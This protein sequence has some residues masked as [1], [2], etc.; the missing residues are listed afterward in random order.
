MGTLRR[1][2]NLC[3]LA[4][5][6]TSTL[7]HSISIRSADADPSDTGDELNLIT[8]DD[9]P[10]SAL[11]PLEH[12][13]I[14]YLAD[15][16][17]PKDIVRA[18]FKCDAG[19]QISNGAKNIYCFYGTWSDEM[20]ECVAVPCPEIESP[21][22]GYFQWIGPVQPY[23]THSIAEFF[24]AE[25]YTHGNVTETAL[26]C[27]ADGTW[28]ST[29]PQ[30]QEETQNL[31]DLI[32]E[33]TS[34]SV[35]SSGLTCF[36]GTVNYEMGS[37]DIV[38]YDD[39]RSI[40]CQPGQTQCFKQTITIGSE[41]WEGVFS[42][43]AVTVGCYNPQTDTSRMTRSNT[44]QYLPENMRL[45]AYQVDLCDT[46]S[47]S[48]ITKDSQETI[49][50]P[51]GLT[52]TD[53]D[54]GAILF[55]QESSEECKVTSFCEVV[56][57]SSTPVGTQK[58]R[59][60]RYTGCGGFYSSN[61]DF[62]NT[63]PV[64]PEASDRVSRMT[65]CQRWNC[66]EGV[67]GLCVCP[68]DFDTTEVSVE[69]DYIPSYGDEAEEVQ[70]SSPK[71]ELHCMTGTVNYN[72]MTA[73]FTYDDTRIEKC[74]SGQTMCF[75]E[76]AVVRGRNMLVK[77][78]NGGC[79]N[80]SFQ[81]RYTAERMKSYLSQT[82]QIR[83]YSFQTCKETNCMDFSD[84]SETISCYF[85]LMVTDSNSGESMF[86]HR[87]VTS[88]KIHETCE[89]VSLD[90]TI[91]STGQRLHFQY[92][93]CG[94]PENYKFDWANTMPIIPPSIEVEKR[95][96]ACADLGCYESSLGL[97]SCPDDF[98][99]DR[100]ARVSVQH[101]ET[102]DSNKCNLVTA[103][104]SVEDASSGT[105][106]GFYCLT[107]TVNQEYESGIV[108]Y[109][110]TKLQ[111]CSYE[112][113]ECYQ[114]TIV[115]NIG[116]WPIKSTAGGCLMATAKRF[117]SN[118]NVLQQ[119]F[120]VDSTITS[121]D[122]ETCSQPGCFNFSPLT[123]RNTITCYSGLTVT[124]ES[125]GRVLFHHQ[126]AQRCKIHNF[127]QVQTLQSTDAHT[128]ETK[129]FR[130]S[131][132]GDPAS[133]HYEWGN[134]LAVVPR[135][136]SDV[137]RQRQCAI[138]GCYEAVLGLCVCQ[139]GFNVEEYATIS[140]KHK[141]QC[142]RNLCNGVE[143]GDS[144]D[145]SSEM[146][147]LTGSINYELES[148]QAIFDN[149][150]VQKCG[151]GKTECYKST[152][153]ARVGNWPIKTVDTGCLQ[154]FAEPFLASRKTMEQY[155]PV[156]S[157]TSSY[158]FEKCSGTN[159]FTLPA[160]RETLQCYSGLVV[161]D[162]ESGEILFQHQ[163][164]EQCKVQDFC[165]TVTVTA[166]NT[167]SGARRNFRYSGCGDAADSQF[168]GWGNMLPIVPKSTDEDLRQRQCA[169][170]NCFERILGM[171]VCQK[172][173]NVADYE[174]L[175]NF[176]KDTCNE[177]LCNRVD[178]NSI[179]AMVS[180]V[181][182]NP[183]SEL[184]CI[185][186]GINLETET[187]TITYDNTKSERCNFGE[188][189]CY[190]LTSVFR[191]D[192]WPVKAIQGACLMPSAETF[193]A[194]KAVFERYL[195]KD[196]TLET[197]EFETCEGDDCFKFA[198][199]SEPVVTCMKGLIVTDNAG[200]VLFSHGSEETCKVHNLC[201]TVYLT[202][203]D[204]N[205][206]QIKHFRYSGCGDPVG[207]S[208]EWS[209]MLPVVPKSS[210][211]GY[212][213]QRQCARYG[214]YE[215]DLGMC[216]CPNDFNV[217]D[218]ITMSDHHKETCTG[219]LCNADD[220]KE[221]PT[222]QLT[223]VTGSVN[224]EVGSDIV[225]YDDTHVKACGFGESQCFKQSLVIN[226]GGWPVKS[227]QGGCLLPTAEQFFRSQDLN[228]KYIPKEST[229]EEY[230]FETCSGSNCFEFAPE[231][232]KE[233]VTC[234]K[235]LTVTN[236]YNDKVLFNHQEEEQC[237]VHNFCQTITLTATSSKWPQALNFRY[238]ACGDP[239]DSKYEW[240]NMLPVVPKSSGEQQRH[241][242]CAK[243]GC[244]ES[245]LGMCLCQRDL[246]VEDYVQVSDFHKEQCDTD[247][248][249][250]AD[251]QDTAASDDSAE[252]SCVTGQV[253]YEPVS[254]YVT[255]DNTKVQT[256][257]VGET[258]CFK[259]RFTARVANWPIDV[260]SAGCLQPFAEN[261]FRSKE[262][263]TEYLPEDSEMTSFEFDT[264][265]TSNCFDV[266][267]ESSQETI[268]CYSGL[269]VTDADTNE[270]IFHNQEAV[271]CKI[272]DFCQAVTLT[273]TNRGS[274]ESSNFRYSGCGDPAGARN[275]WSNALPV[276][277]KSTDPDRRQRQC[278]KWGCYE[279]RL[280]LCVCQR[281]FNTEDHATLSNYHKT[282]CDE[283]LCNGVSNFDPISL[284]IVTSGSLT[285]MAGRV[286]FELESGVVTYD[287][288]HEETCE[289]SQTECYTQTVIARIENW[290]VK[291]V[292]GG[293]LM[294]M[295]EQFLSNR[296]LNERYLPSGSIIR[297]FEFEKC[298]GSNCFD[299]SP[300][301]ASNTINCYS[302][303]TVTDADT[304][305]AI[306]HQQE[307]T[308]CKIYNFCQT[309]S[310]TATDV[311]TNQQNNFVY[312]GC[313]D[314]ANSNF[315]WGK[316]LPVVPQSTQNTQVR[317]RQ[318]ARYGCFEGVLGMCVC[319][320]GFSPEDHV[321][322]SNY[323]KSQCTDEL[324]NGA[325]DASSM[326]ASPY[327]GPI[328][329]VTGTVN[330][331]LESGQ[332]TYDDTKSKECSF[333]QTQ[334][335]TQTIT[336]V[337]DNWPL[338]TI[339][340]GCLSPFAE[341]F[342]SNE[343][344]LERYFPEGSTFSSF[345]FDKCEGNNCNNFS[346]ED[347]QP[348]L[349]CQSG[350]TV[351]DQNTG[352]VLFHHQEETQCKVHNFCQT[353]SLTTTSNNGE[354]K[355]FRYYGCGDPADTKHEWGNM[356][357]VVPKSKNEDRRQRQCSRWGCYESVLGMC[358]CQ[359]GFNVAAYVNVDNHN[360]QQCRENLC[361]GID[362]YLSS[363]VV[364]SQMSC[365]TGT[366]NKGAD[367]GRVTY[368]DT[369]VKTCDFGQTR[370]Y[371]R[372]FVTRF[373]KWPIVNT[374][375][376]CLMPSSEVW[377]SSK[378]TMEQFLPENAAIESF[379]F[380]TCTGSN[381][382]D[383]TPEDSQTTVS[384]YS[385]LSVTNTNTGEVVFH[386]MEE[387]QCKVHDF[388][389][390]ITLTATNAATNEQQNFRYSGCGDPANTNYEWGKTIPV[391]PK[392]LNEQR[393]QRQCSRFGC[394]EQVL[395]MCVCQ[396]DTNTEDYVSLANYRKQQCNGDLCNG[397]DSV[398]SMNFQPSSQLTCM[399]GSFNYDLESRQ[400][401]YDDVQEQTC[402][403]GI[404][405][406][407]K[408]DV[409][410]M[411]ENYRARYV[412][413][414]CLHPFAEAFLK[415][416][417][418]ME[419][420][421]A[422]DMTIQSLSF[423]KCDGSNCF[424]VSLTSSQ[425]TIQC[426]KGV[427]ITDAESGEVI[428]NQQEPVQCKVH[429]FCQV[430]TLTA[431]TTDSHSVR[432]YRYS[433][434]GDPGNT[435]MEWGN[436]LPVVPVSEDNAMVRQRQ[437]AKWGCYEHVLGMCLCT[438]D[439]DTE[440]YVS[441]TNYYKDQCQDNLCNGGTETMVALVQTASCMTGT[442][443]LEEA[444]G[445]VTYDDSTEQACSLGQFE[446]Y[447]QTMHAVIDGWPIQ[448]IEGGCLHPFAEPL[449]KSSKVMESFFPQGSS[450]K[451]LDFEKCE[452]TNCM[453]LSSENYPAIN[454]FSGVT[455]TDSATGE[456]MFHHEEEREC[457][458]N[459]FCQVVTLT[460][461][462]AYTQNS[463]EFRYSG[464]GD[465][466]NTKY[467]WGKMLP[468]VPKSTDKMNRQRQCYRF[469]CYESVLGMCIC[470]SNFNVEDYAL[471]SEHNK[472]QCSADLCN[473]VSGSLAPVNPNELSCQTGRV[474]FEPKS[475]MVTYDDVQEKACDFGQ[476][477][478]YTQT[479]TAIVESWPIQIVYGG[480][481]MPFS[482]PFLS[483]KASAENYL[484]EGSTLEEFAFDTC[485]GSN[486]FDF[487]RSDDTI[488]CYS[489]LTVTDDN[490][491]VQFHQQ[492]QVQCK[493]HNYCQITT[494]SSTDVLSNTRYNFKLA[495]C[496]DPYNGMHEWSNVL[497][498]IPKSS[499]GPQRQRQCI[500][501][502]CFE[503]VLGL[504]VCP[505]DFNVGDVATLAN[506][507]KEQCEDDL[508]NGVENVHAAPIK[509]YVLD[510]VTCIDGTV[511]FEP[512]SG[513][514]T[515]DDTRE[516]TCKF[517]RSQCYKQ[518]MILMMGQWPI[519]TIAGGCLNPMAEPFLSNADIM[520]EYLPEDSSVES[521]N[522]ETCHGN[523]CFDFSPESSMDTIECY[524]GLTVT[525]AATGDV[526]FH[527]QE[528]Q[529]CKVHN[530]CQTVTLS[531]TSDNKQQ[532]FRYSGCGDPSNTMFEWGKVLPF[533][534]MSATDEGY[535]QRQCAKYGCYE[536]ILGLCVCR[537]DVDPADYVTLSNFNKEQCEEELCNGVANVA[538]MAPIKQTAAEFTCMTGY[539]N[540][541]VLSGLITY[542]NTYNA[543]CPFGHTQCYQQTVV[544][545]VG[546]WPIE[547]T[548]GG[549][550]NP[551]AKSFL[552][553]QDVMEE[554]F[555]EDATITSFDFKTCS[556]S[557]CF[558][559][560]PEDSK[561]TISCY[562]GLTVTDDDTD[563]VVFHHQ[564]PVQCKLYEF[565][566]VVTLKSSNPSTQKT[567]SYRYSGCGDPVD[568]NFEWGNKLPFVPKSLDT[569]VRQHQCAANG[570]Y[571]AILGMCVCARRFDVESIA[572]VSDFNKI[573]CSEALC[574]GDDVS[575]DG[576]GS[577]FS[578]ITGSMNLEV[579]TDFVTFDNTRV[580]KC[581][582]GQTQCY[583]RTVTATHGS[584]PVKFVDGGCL[585]PRAENF[586]RSREVTASFLPEEMTIKTHE[587]ETCDSANCNSF[588]DSDDSV[589]CFSGLH[590]TD[591][592]DQVVYNKQ[593][594]VQCKV[595]NFCQTI[596]VSATSTDTEETLNYKISGC[597]DPAYTMFEW[598]NIMPVVPRSDEA[599][600]R[601]RQCAAWGCFEKALGVCVCPNDFNVGSLLTLSDINKEQ[602]T[603][604]LC[605]GV[606]AVVASGHLQCHSGMV[607]SRNGEAY[608][609]D[610][611]TETCDVGVTQCYKQTIDG[612]V[613]NYPVKT[614]S[615]GCLRPRAE[616]FLS[617]QA[618]M[619][620]YFPAGSTFS[621]FNMETCDTS[622]CLDLSAGLTESE[623]TLVCYKG[624]TVEENNEVIF[625]SHKALQCKI[626]DYCQTVT[627]TKTDAATR[628][629]QHFTLT[630]CGD[631]FD[632]VY[633]W[634]SVLP[635][636]PQS[637]RDD[638][639]QR[640][641]AAYGCYEAALGVCNCKNDFDVSA[642]AKLSKFN[643][644]RCNDDLCNEVTSGSSSQASGELSCQSGTI[645]VEIESG[646]TTY[647]DTVESTCAFG[648]S[649][650]YK[651]T[652]TAVVD[653]WPIKT[654][655]MGCLMPPSEPFLSSQQVFESF[656]PEDSVTSFAF[657]KCQGAMCFNESP[658]SANTIN[659]YKGLSVTDSKSGRVLFHEQNPTQCKVNEFC[660]VVT[661][662]AKLQG[663]RK[664]QNF[665]FSGCGDPA[666]TQFEWGRDHIV[667]IIPTSSDEGVRQRQCSEHGCFH[668][669]STP[670]LCMCKRDVNLEK[671][672]KLSDLQKEICQANLCNGV[673]RNNIPS[674]PSASAQTCVTGVV[675]YEMTSG[676]VS[677]DDSH[678]ETC[679]FGHNKCYTQT[680]IIN[681]QGWQVKTVSGGCL[682]PMAE[683]FLSDRDLNEEYL[684]ED[685]T[686]EDFDFE[687]CTG[688]NCNDITP[689]SSR[690]TITCY[691]GLTVTDDSTGDVLFKHQEE[692][693]CKVHSFCQT[694]KLQAAS[695][696]TQQ[697]RT[698]VYTDCGDP[699]NTKYEWGNILP[700]IPKKLG[701]GH[702]Q[703]QCAQWGCF[704][705]SLGMCVCKKDF[706]VDA[707]MSVSNHHKVQCTSE[708]CNTDEAHSVAPTLTTCM[709]GSVHI[710][711]DT[712]KIYYDD[713]K[714][715]TCS[716]GVTHC[717]E[718]VI[719]GRSANF[720][721][722][723]SYGGCLEPKAEAFLRNRVLVEQYFPED[724]TVENYEFNKCKG[725]NCFALSPEDSYDTTQCFSGLTVTDDESGNVLFHHQEAVQCKIHDFCQ[726]VTV[727]TESSGQTRNFRYTGCGDPTNSKFEWG[728]VIPVVPTSTVEERRQ[729]QCYSYG[730]YE[731]VL[732][733]CV[734]PRNLDA[735]AYATLLTF[736]K[737][738]CDGVLCNQVDENTPMNTGPSGLTC[739]SG[740]VYIELSSGMVVHDD[741]KT[742]ACS[743]GHN[744]CYK[745][746]IDATFG[747]WPA[748]QII[749]GCLPPQ[750]ETFLSRQELI[751]SYFNEDT[752][753]QSFDFD[754]CT[755]NNCFSISPSS[756]EETITCYAGVTITDAS[757]GDVVFHHQEPQQCKIHNFCQTTFLTAADSDGTHNFRYSGCGETADL[758]N[759][760]DRLILPVVPQSL[761]KHMRE[762]QCFMHGCFETQLGLCNCHRNKDISQVPTLTNFKKD[763]CQAALC[764]KE[765]VD[766]L[767]AVDTSVLTCVAGYVVKEMDS[768]VVT[769]DDTHVET[770]RFGRTECFTKT[771]VTVGHGNWRVQT[772]I[773]GC[774]MPR[775][776]S[777]LAS[778]EV[779]ESYLPADWSISSFD[780]N[781]C[782][783]SNCNDFSSN[784][785]TETVMCNAG[786]T[787]KDDS[788]G[789]VVYEQHEERE[790]KSVNNNNCQTVTL[791]TT[792]ATSGQKLNYQY[793]GCGD[794]GNNLY[795]W[796]NSMPV[797]PAG[798]RPDQRNRQCFKYGCFEGTLGMC[799]CQDGFDT[800]RVKTVSDYHKEQCIGDLCNTVSDFKAASGSQQMTCLTGAVHI[801]DFTG[802]TYYDDTQVKECYQGQTEC[803]KRS[804]G[805][806]VENNWPVTYVTYGCLA[807][808]SEAFLKSQSVL[809]D[810]LPRDFSVVDFSFDKCSGANC[811]ELN[812]DAEN[813]ITCNSG[814]TVTDRR[815]GD[816]VYN[817]VVSKQCKIHNYCQT[818]TVTA[819][820][821]DT[822]QRKDFTYA[823]CGNVM[824]NSI[825]KWGNILP[826]VPMSTKANN[827]QR[828]CIKYGCYE[829]TLGMCV[830]P[831]SFDRDSHVELSN[832]NKKHCEE[833]NCNTVQP[834]TSTSRHL[835]C[836]SG[837]V[838]SEIQSGWTNYDD[839]HV[840][841]CEFGVTECY[842][843]TV[844][845]SIGK[846][847]IKTVTGGCLLPPSKP[848]LASQDVM[849]S[850]FP[851]D[852]AITSFDFDTCTNS[853]CFDISP[854]NSRDTLTCYKGVTI[855]DASSG[856]VVFHNQE[857]V[858]CKVHNHCQTIT[859]T[860]TNLYSQETHNY[861]YASCGDPAN[862][863]VG[864][865]WGNEMPVIPKSIKKYHRQRQCAKF[866][867]YEVALGMCVCQRDFNLKDHISLSNYHKEQ[868]QEDN[869]NGA[870]SAPSTM[871][872]EDQQQQTCI[873]G[874]VNFETDTGRVVFDDTKEV[875]CGFGQTKCFK[876]TMELAVS[877]W[878]ETSIN[879]GC[880]HPF[881]EPFLSS[882]SVVASYFP[883]D[884]AITQYDFDTCTGA[885]CFN[886]SPEGSK[887]TITCYSGLTVTDASTGAE[888][889]N[890]HEEQH[891]KVHNFCDTI[892]LTSTNAD[893]GKRSKFVYTGCG[894]P[895]NVKFALWGNM[896][897]V[898]PSSV[899]DHTRQRQCQTWGCYESVMGMCIC[900]AGMNVEMY[901]SVSDLQ[902]SSCSGTLCNGVD[903][904]A[905]QSAGNDLTC[906]TGT[907][908][909]EEK[910][911]MVTYDDTHQES[912]WFG[913][914]YCYKQVMHLTM[915]NWP[916]TTTVGGCLMPMSEPFLNNENVMASYLPEN[917]P[918]TGFS[919]EKCTG[920][921]CFNFASDAQETLSCYDG[922][923]VTSS[924]GNVEYRSIKEKRCKVH[925]FCQTTTMQ[926]T[927]AYS[928]ENKMFTFYGCGDPADTKYEWGNVLPV[929][930]KSD[931]IMLRQRQCAQY[932]CFEDSLGL[933]VCQS[934]FN[935]ADYV[936][937]SIHSKQQCQG[938]LCNNEYAR[939]TEQSCIEGVVSYEYESGDVLYDSTRETTCG[940]GQTQCYKYTL[941]AT[942]GNFPIK[943]VHAGCLMPFAEAFFR[944]RDLQAKYL[945]EDGSLR[946]YEFDTC[947]GSNCFD[948]S[949]DAED[950]IS[951]YD[952][953]TVIDDA[954]GDVL[955]H[956]QESVQC[957]LH[958][959][960][961]RVSISST[962][963]AGKQ[964]F[965]YTGC[966][967]PYG[968]SSFS[969]GANRLPV[970][971]ASKTDADARQRQCAEW[972]CFEG[973]IGMCVC[974]NDFDTSTVATVAE[975]N[976]QECYEEL[977]NKVDG[978][979]PLYS[980][981][982]ASKE[983]LTCLSG[984]VS[985][986]NGIVSFDD[987][988]EVTCGFGYSKCYQQ[989]IR[990]ESGTF[991]MEAISG[992]C[993]FPMAEPFLSN[994]ALS[995]KYMPGHLSMTDFEFDS[996][997]ESNCL[998]FSDNEE[999]INCY[1000]GLT[1001][1002]EARSGD[1003]IFY[1004][1005]EAQACKVSE[1006]CQVVTYT[1007][1008][1009][1010]E[1011]GRAHNFRYSGCGD[1012]YNTKYTWGNLLP[1013]VPQSLQETR[1014][1015]RQCYRF[1016]CY[1017]SVLGMCVCQSDFPVDKHVTLDN[1018]HKARCEQ[1019]LCNGNSDVSG[1020]I[1021]TP[1022]K[1023]V[1024][1025]EVVV[1026]TEP[1027]VVVPP[1028]VAV[1029]EHAVVE[1030]VV[1031]E[1032]PET[1033]DEEEEATPDFESEALIAESAL[1034]NL[1035]KVSKYL[1036]K[1037]IKGLYSYAYP[1038][1039]QGYVWNGQEWVWGNNELSNEIFDGGNKVFFTYGSDNGDD[1040]VQ[1041][1042]YGQQYKFDNHEFSTRTGEPFHAVMWIDNTSDEQAAPFKYRIE[1043]TPTSSDGQISKFHGISRGKN[1044]YAG[1045]KFS[1046]H[1047]AVF[1048]VNQAKGSDV[1049][1050][1051]SE[1052]YYVVSST[1053]KWDSSFNGDMDISFAD[1054]IGDTR[1055]SVALSART[1056]NAFFGY[1057]LLAKDSKF[1058]K[1059]DLRRAIRAILKAYSHVD[1060]PG[1061]SS[1062]DRKRTAE[1063]EQWWK[1064][1065]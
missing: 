116:K 879:G 330:K 454:C 1063:E 735:E 264:C 755:G 276:I 781:S 728:K 860:A 988:K 618:I 993:L 386:H 370:C 287:D 847:P 935:A 674:P 761:D 207:T 449:L 539:V 241:R 705:Q 1012:A 513:M 1000:S 419:A 263:M 529:Q 172:T 222:G 954:T 122:F 147:C 82:V 138:W 248:C 891:C 1024:E 194:S 218:Y 317:Q 189:Q 677:Y 1046:L 316:L 922:L 876:Q 280:G 497:P 889:F 738:K 255:Y 943:Q 632:S 369:H 250:G 968:G 651:Q 953:V 525:D 966:G 47:C 782:S 624:I 335:Y 360:K 950:T 1062:G 593:D 34:T 1026:P 467:E 211:N 669:A 709:S 555:P 499:N 428:F 245:V 603:G 200:E 541:E 673:N 634:G 291:Y 717:Y 824:A 517:G 904:T 592:D 626:T 441:I 190:K 181:A 432:H 688:A 281:N 979:S 96:E 31:D 622:N 939:P 801:E 1047:Y 794:P 774:L 917:F 143:N 552:A 169:G 388:C 952:G 485:E 804:I 167:D 562:S 240:G 653:G 848:F 434:C 975:F 433:G 74:A 757:S 617:N 1050:S 383:F 567:Q 534:P 887:E 195:P 546:N 912:C 466:A 956:H 422:D 199:D 971:P 274:Q 102:C 697:S 226:V 996:C 247:L 938:D 288:T 320:Q 141:S 524:L 322:L 375:G 470:R 739:E 115:A 772:S 132:C 16:R 1051:T 477:K 124:S 75:K 184:S 762:R 268:M 448:T 857:S 629:K 1044:K 368:D 92:S 1056:K 1049:P 249:N 1021:M 945:P 345:A 1001:V 579:G 946:S 602:C 892:T 793:V 749:G 809:E 740:M 662:T 1028:V 63:L 835:T 1040:L 417:D 33:A 729:R 820:D 35:E 168:F 856:D 661:L 452:G 1057:S 518:T 599:D 334:C 314:P 520:A 907:V 24:C 187:G 407:Y 20:P 380:D 795:E 93:G 779:L 333:G 493:L 401:T 430:T 839:T 495:G 812:S 526:L 458:V 597:A 925:N 11:D 347:S 12:G 851:E 732:G 19:Y 871:A 397:A 1027:E 319:Q 13:S 767:S 377:L 8:N 496:G 398:G 142:G 719:Q 878:P 893:T 294:P 223:C 699:Y 573:Q 551:Y 695:S 371:K 22:N 582:F 237:K 737:E 612:N 833:D 559:Y 841:T 1041:A 246:N 105:P 995:T 28:S 310:L 420:Y 239:A 694:T 660:Q 494:L 886:L 605:N 15:E 400:T 444:T 919:F 721:V 123:S 162:D 915:D 1020:E 1055:N 983:P 158:Q 100:H 574:N 486:C 569:N 252:F 903:N 885:N 663:Q 1034:K 1004:H 861:R 880:L 251:E 472:E 625:T 1013:V 744:R 550:L 179:N 156:N 867:C 113:T 637:M 530:Y 242:Q 272:H 759:K 1019:D 234:Y 353:V 657:E 149:T 49:I 773:G 418:L 614:V 616:A 159:C 884:T 999:N 1009:S 572:V 621:N 307:R 492:E 393:R 469:G 1025:P 756:S 301:S 1014:R 421:L 62:S 978:E 112:Q 459:S 498:F 564:E 219:S 67:L 596:E 858:Q 183:A 913:V 285:C 21:D 814:V 895:Y 554:Y 746:D 810:F 438:R 568:T 134:I 932:G 233:T 959:F 528:E 819:T 690:N 451:S 460:S 4:I 503:S 358:V 348:T 724:F 327:T 676:Q 325:D 916:V 213:R 557:N 1052:L 376:G 854:Q 701:D 563:A 2:L 109:D 958:D 73:T 882:K 331:E 703:R 166:Q 808:Q 829:H 874:T 636:V 29:V 745:Q 963:S 788:T 229:L 456:V 989:T 641:C 415:N 683:S 796:A 704:S 920:S 177:D 232:S 425:D 435:Q 1064:Y 216:I 475:G 548:A 778:R 429:D 298:S 198:P 387:K 151:Y 324:C 300:P 730:C 789:A 805:M 295:S 591:E 623:E 864:S 405:E 584:W 60:F 351:T 649:E 86:A 659:C 474:S 942:I 349:T 1016:G 723:V 201:Q 770:C 107:G 363:P 311:D 178:A 391:V 698:F 751:A 409:F 361:N 678:Q 816:V 137:D 718:Q 359:Q 615:G 243:W 1033:E 777:F 41:L 577:D 508:C 478:C 185:T 231:S 436:A 928:G 426:Y 36:H 589:K 61:F 934:D 381:C 825:F 765:N 722:K 681:A 157:Y 1031:T 1042:P 684:P 843:Q 1038:T 800:S 1017:E 55:S 909:V 760:L 535:R 716:F 898:V 484:P 992:G 980:P 1008:T 206:R 908:N 870:A 117:L 931:D 56:T 827:R 163:E 846:W 845:A 1032:A 758:I 877:A 807:P 44:E 23:L 326:S 1002:T 691:A 515:Y 985:S 338:K 244:F 68:R 500:K 775:A 791:S 479:F 111:S 553:S 516:V 609:D 416:K 1006:F 297:S 91:L 645:N 806:R 853:N 1022:P 84:A 633:S 1035:N 121:F 821:A 1059:K 221:K 997:S 7:T 145:D 726:T 734:C 302:G 711:K 1036:K 396:R 365:I 815:S 834:K 364:P 367:D 332:V 43:N 182:V 532:N 450:V 776:E 463:Y 482:E 580:E 445:V 81:D 828:Q 471:V 594:V 304:G 6:F 114:Q 933:C 742:Q 628:K 687:T 608:Y 299:Y 208:Y 269:T 395:G 339:A 289:F 214:C 443:T 104:V 487:S 180:G 59:V 507:Y 321:K 706:N 379:D 969:W 1:A 1010:S 140:N 337:V 635:V 533:V 476:T 259:Q 604:S 313:G 972:G 196:G 275:S 53:K 455:I 817:N 1030:E 521:L 696:Y 792:D 872:V 238:S 692:K 890:H 262:L 547:T 540:K 519:K 279:D 257:Q 581:V 37:D 228:E 97:C 918:I 578:C 88:C 282:S 350:L 271:Q 414:G 354:T 869:C 667:P 590:V 658:D 374:V 797:V 148:G 312:T 803:F 923:A 648:I 193:L 949:S 506:Y 411:K 538:L 511:N 575:T 127:C 785:E 753:I 71:S 558:D 175:S 119:Y 128:G 656:V 188:T 505:T 14:S 965:I 951:C 120:P 707:Y 842:K 318:C 447:K 998:D 336:A 607:N 235:G 638:H 583:T 894:D 929:V 283:S 747:T 90:K 566:Q 537:R 1048:Q 488:M 83:G 95:N 1023:P 30:C 26:I 439:F 708:L 855:S 236:D 973:V 155:M 514:V 642:H 290:P 150:K 46:T 1060:I 671:V 48:E 906:M 118:R 838:N 394:Y 164:A 859:L 754:T 962:G 936:S 372:S 910:S 103:V 292:T 453:E 70:E 403:F 727:S 523:N 1039:E 664:K 144:E 799:I 868:C 204:M 412:Y 392:S 457:K 85:G 811:M 215:R 875:T 106:S 261:F 87:E 1029:T 253:N 682:H 480:C 715:H 1054:E 197:F 937:V 510:E 600:I 267:P 284:G 748:K 9:L 822:R 357:P 328:S 308:Q 174:T 837:T 1005:E 79:M 224:Q 356:L 108:T 948:V 610:A 165:Q 830:C 881:A 899:E 461:Q 974:P 230:N 771:I 286:N 784:A 639:R 984:T 293:C 408:Q 152:I 668:V 542:D 964:N 763:I 277:P 462:E 481:L 844:V 802:A 278:A 265:T 1003:V 700:V 666:N 561:E 655:A 970:V 665:R 341:A 1045:D 473:G 315:E 544:V 323:H 501:Y 129:N 1061:H 840:E 873:S 647:D 390:T 346:P 780:F 852:T 522:W 619:E 17:W 468:V 52:V 736:N 866:G 504:C 750:A 790:C 389:Q 384:C 944:N 427:T 366:V 823:D 329:C 202:T 266:S 743:F 543:V 601:Q 38:E 139:R 588:S 352:G 94:D 130:F 39:V 273:S 787:I 212:H 888:L 205:T 64:I 967:D 154:P 1011:T 586:L 1065:W 921:N 220:S 465:P 344:V 982:A 424:P 587:F 731:A 654:T 710:Q 670:G 897:P 783:G 136:K 99:A 437:C 18:H 549:C 385:G 491:E 192:N 831:T 725:H 536:S 431:E 733:M 957:K 254:G 940:F 423:D 203:T 176:N 413:G 340:G 896:L 343:D 27:K 693:Q 5:I 378:D 78:T 826:V 355:Y 994:R 652:V 270:V 686:V 170:H 3:F 512:N 930:P 769:Y 865:S 32:N 72:T 627:F 210:D 76:S 883:E 54:T 977:C 786:L 924:N 713:T 720:P 598:G 832:L 987:T 489:G 373:G 305:D 798:D 404:T 362:N 256:C 153:T 502:G 25:G 752:T 65:Q 225:T 217:Q 227:T 186:G 595:H 342:L 850:Y 125:S 986:N 42:M 961:Q 89:T 902:K 309:V 50:C 58:T 135:S 260:T 1007:V 10:C 646:R 818:V 1058:Q 955:F 702:Q 741:V 133:T 941:T 849:E 527:H 640:Q 399:T 768:G 644:R 306:F 40:R 1053:D 981:Q 926:T 483:S 509:K 57:V 131:G 675:N 863:W 161:T 813:T 531:S 560:S 442:V 900:K 960:C 490:G 585:M 571:E 613:N 98:D 258:E 446:C 914:N 406:C 643:K 689:D 976:K 146:S 160:T 901:V 1018:Y 171:C 565:C 402:P 101:K 947:T 209:N 296:A 764:N 1037:K 679:K 110:D 620:S 650:C 630:D 410:L 990:S 440:D 69:G 191:I 836:V 45:D 303:L 80:P 173:L 911:G 714:E 927:N 382:L 51:A 712:G 576:S 680:M 556:G 905:P 685:I 766:A 66:Y 570:C 606:E 631:K 672:A 611:H 1015:Q 1043:G 77:H 862:T 464:C 126:E 991:N 545:T